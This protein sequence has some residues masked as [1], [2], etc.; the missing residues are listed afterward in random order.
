MASLAIVTAPAAEPVTSVEAKAHLRVTSSAED[1]LIADRIKAARR[2]CER[3]CRR[4]FITQTLRLRMDAFPE[5]LRLP[6]GTTASVT[7]ITYVDGDGTT[8]TLAADRYQTDLDTVPAR[9]VPAYGYS[10][11]ATRSQLAAVTVTY[12]V[13]ASAADDDVKAALLMV[14][15]DLY[16]NREA[17]IIA[18]S[19]VANPAVQ[20]LLAAHRC[21]VLG[22]ELDEIA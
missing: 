15:A 17:S 8:Q 13:G 6:F 9:I 5:M 11:P 18:A 19:Y 2:W 16:E 12:V 20:S 14:L 4:G 21:D 7:S 22:I 10:W 3:Y 1:T